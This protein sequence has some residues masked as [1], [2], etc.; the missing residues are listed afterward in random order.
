MPA[1]QPMDKPRG[2]QATLPKNPVTEHGILCL[3]LAK[4][5]NMDK[6][7]SESSH[8]DFGVWILGHPNS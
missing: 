1:D 8:F 5:Q 7:A 2:N 4:L 6:F 3:S